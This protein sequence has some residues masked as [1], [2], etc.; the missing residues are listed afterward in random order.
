[1]QNTEKC[2]IILVLCADYLLNELGG[3]YTEFY[4]T[5]ET[6]C[7]TLRFNS[8]SILPYVATLGDTLLLLML[9]C[10]SKDKSMNYLIKINRSQSTLC[11]V[12]LGVEQR[13]EKLISICNQKRF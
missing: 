6:T 10:F 3:I 12:D 13:S 11:V 4:K 2:Q 9:F 5:N 7:S 1:M 8:S